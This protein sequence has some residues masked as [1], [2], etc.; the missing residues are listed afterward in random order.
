MHILMTGAT[1]FVGHHLVDY[2]EKEGHSLYILTRSEKQNKGKTHY[3]KWSI[4][5]NELPDLS[6]TPI[7]ICINLAGASINGAR[8][9]RDYKEKIIQSRLDATSKLLEIVEQ[10]ETKP[11]LWINAS[12]INI[13]PSSQHTIYLD[14]EENPK[15]DSFLAYTVTRWES[16]AKEAETLGIRVVFTRFGLILGNDGGAFPVFKKMFTFFIGGRF[17]RGNNW[18]SFI[19]IDDLVR[20]YAHIIKHSEINGIVNLT[21]PHPV[22]QKNFAAYL[23]QKMHRPSKLII[24][25]FAIKLGGGERSDVLLESQRAYPKKLME[26]QFDFY[27]PTIEKTIT[28]LL[29]QDESKQ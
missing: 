3:I 15:Q 21:T 27:Y 8:W 11:V 17:A 12:A 16:K 20:G 25:K 19:H 5:D 26:S 13:Y 1:G 14:T 22:M 4:T 7:D 29:D 28:T 10:M 23:G 2:F 9:T 6:N 24:P 18:Y